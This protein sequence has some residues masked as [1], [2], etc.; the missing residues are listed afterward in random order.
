MT[1]ESRVNSVFVPAT[2]D[3]RLAAVDVN[4]GSDPSPG[5]AVPARVALR[6]GS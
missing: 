1:A 5:A 2:V 3:E 6:G 4:V